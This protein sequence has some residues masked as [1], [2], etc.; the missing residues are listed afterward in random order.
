MLSFYAQPDSTVLSEGFSGFS[1]PCHSRDGSRESVWTVS[2]LVVANINDGIS[3]SKSLP[4]VLFDSL[5]CSDRAFQDLESI[6]T[7]SRV[8]SGFNP[9]PNSL[10][11]EAGLS[12]SLSLCSDQYD[13][14]QESRNGSTFDDG[15]AVLAY[16]DETR[17]RG[18]VLSEFCVRVDETGIRLQ[19]LTEVMQREHSDG[20][21]R[22]AN[23][24]AR[25]GR[26]PIVTRSMTAAQRAL[27]CSILGNLNDQNNHCP[28]DSSGEC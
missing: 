15:P 22:A 5:E 9:P 7:S 26:S 24:L 14:S 21:G 27:E 28:D 18:D 17:E 20:P 13:S 3:R 2:E 12:S 11:E 8:F 4:D 6:L 25:R 19:M 23:A 16:G 10:T 1:Q